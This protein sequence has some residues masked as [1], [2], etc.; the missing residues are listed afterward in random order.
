MSNPLNSYAAHYQPD[1]SKADREKT[2]GEKVFNEVT[3]RGID[4]ALNAAVGVSFT[5]WTGR[6][7]SGLKYFGAPVERFFEKTLKP[8]I[9]DETARKKAVGAGRNFVS[10]MAGGTAIIPPIMLLEGNKKAVVES[11]DR[12]IYGDEEVDENPRFAAAYHAIDNEPYKSFS[13][14]MG[15]RFVAL[16]PIFAAAL[17]APDQCERILYNPIGDIS[18]YTAKTVG[19][20]GTKLRNTHH[21]ASSGEK[22]SDWD[23]VHK[24]I[25]MDVGLTFIYSYLHEYSYRALSYLG[26]KDTAPSQTPP[27]QPPSASVDVP[28]IITHK[29]VTQPDHS[30]A[31][32]GVSV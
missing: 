2:A 22:Q 5:Y 28:S 4:F 8:I 21:I 30:A 17:G 26:H 7:H 18:K 11:L 14:G 23:F 32:S 6:T 9:T 20:K 1:T 3:Y 16:A 13:L 12:R 24:T 10:I 31:I 29:T 15:A 19:I 27:D 25:G